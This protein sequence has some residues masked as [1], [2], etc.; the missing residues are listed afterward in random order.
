[1]V[2]LV[3]AL[4]IPATAQDEKKQPKGD[5][6][7][8]EAIGDRDVDGK[9]NFYSLDKEVALG[10]QLA[11]EVARTS[12]IVRDPLIAEY[13]NRLGQNIG[14]SSDAQVPLS[15]QVVD[16]PSINAFALPG[17]F[18]FVNTG[19]LLAADTEAELVG[20]LAHEIAH[21]AARHGT[22]QATRGQLANYATLPLMFLGGW[23]GFGIRQAASLAI[24]MTFLQFSKGFEREADYLGVQY[25]YAS[26]Y[27]PAGFVDF[28][29]KL[30]A[31]EKRKPGTIAKVFRS[32]PLTDDR[33]T[34]AQ[35]EIGLI[36]PSKPEYRV[37]SSEF[38]DVKERLML[39]KRPGKDAPDDSKPRI[40]RAGGRIDPSGESSP[41]GIEDDDEPPVLRRGDGAEAEPDED[42]PPVIRRGGGEP[43]SSTSEPATVEDPEDDGP[44]VLRRK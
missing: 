4:A 27:D 7:D 30:Q 17:G 18:L 12:K 43:S 8:V 1:M 35:E 15:F 40:V 6:H 36:L 42:A 31:Q 29:E 24:P 26:G 10:K 16:D 22:R 11:D 5:K 41:T 32:H 34:S 3:L 13:V 21:V 14:R 28:F 38:L 44:P 19:L 20:V 2:L 37:S 23:A 25:L 39:M 9:L 33:I